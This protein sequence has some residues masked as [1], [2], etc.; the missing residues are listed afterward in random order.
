ESR[1]S[2]P[3]QGFCHAVKGRLDARRAAS[4]GS[5]QVQ[6]KGQDDFFAIELL[7]LPTLLI[8]RLSQIIL[9]SALHAL[10]GP[11][12]DGGHRLA[13]PDPL[14]LR[15][16]TLGVNALP[17]QIVRHSLPDLAKVHAV[18]LLLG[19]ALSY[20]PS[21]TASSPHQY[22]RVSPTYTGWV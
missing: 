18:S 13:S 9:E 14:Q 8:V 3:P 6:P 15:V 17:L 20:A 1:R 12:G 21:R 5:V 16:G 7:P 22:T 19:T 10:A 2:L 4:L 11:E